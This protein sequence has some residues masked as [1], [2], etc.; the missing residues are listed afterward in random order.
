MLLLPLL[1]DNKLNVMLLPRLLPVNKLRPMLLLPLLLVNRFFVVF[2][3]FD[4]SFVLNNSFQAERDAAAATAAR[5]QAEHRAR[6]AEAARAAAVE[7]ARQAEAA[8]RA[9]EQA[10]AEG[11]F[12]FSLLF[13]FFLFWFVIFY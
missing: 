4:F 6:E 7:S 8:R 1:R 12:F 10:A 3:V 9:A 5:Q 2:Y 11:F 13:S